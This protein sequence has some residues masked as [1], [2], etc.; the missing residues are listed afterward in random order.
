MACK[1]P[2]EWFNVNLRK[3]R[4]EDRMAVEED[5]SKSAIPTAQRLLHTLLL[6][7]AESAALEGARDLKNISRCVTKNGEMS[8][9]AVF[10]IGLRVE[11]ECIQSLC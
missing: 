1:F 3:K 4:E 6:L 10:Y 5:C 8:F 9:A 7:K 11:K 2:A